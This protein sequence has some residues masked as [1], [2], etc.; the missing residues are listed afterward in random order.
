M[1]A[2]AETEIFQDFCDWQMRIGDGTEAYKKV[3]VDVTDDFSLFSGD[4][5]VA[6]FPIKARALSS[7]GRIILAP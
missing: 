5:K 4:V 3:K 2:G 1:A 7:S 6:V